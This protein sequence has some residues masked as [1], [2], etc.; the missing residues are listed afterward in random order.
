MRTIITF[1]NDLS[2]SISGV[3]RMGQDHAQHVHNNKRVCASV[4][5]GDEDV[6]CLSKKK[7]KI[8]IN[9]VSFHWTVVRLSIDSDL[10]RLIYLQNCGAYVSYSHK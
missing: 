1:S 6:E 9:R 8:E 10:P 7:S 3:D 2:L 4:M 5:N